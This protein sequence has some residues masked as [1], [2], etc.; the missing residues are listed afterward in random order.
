MIS[1]DSENVVLCDVDDTLVM[2][3]KN[4][5][6]PGRGK[7]KVYDPY[8]KTNVYL[9]PHKRHIELL[10]TY[11]GRG[12]MVG[13]WTAAGYKW[14]Q[15]VIKTLKIEKYVHFVMTKPT[16]YM[17]D[18]ENPK[19]ILGSRVYLKPWGIYDQLLRLRYRVAVDNEFQNSFAY[20]DFK[21]FGDIED[22]EAL[23]VK[24]ETK[25]QDP[26][27][28]IGIYLNFKQVALVKNKAEALKVVEKLIREAPPAA[29]KDFL[30]YSEI[31][32]KRLK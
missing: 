29:Q 3:G 30:N 10:K 4:Y 9:K 8:G 23:E 1:L 7:V 12:I 15:S 28:A 32:I 21:K 25:R 20:L 17:D 19:D 13:V 14:A 6:K 2:W 5:H 11:K 24:G 26:T 18:L 16:K 31:L 22:F 27:D